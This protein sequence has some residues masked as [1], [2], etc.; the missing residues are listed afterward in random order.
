[1]VIMT[2]MEK[3]CRPCPSGRSASVPVPGAG[4][5]RLAGELLAALLLVALVLGLFWRVTGFEFVFDDDVYVTDV[6]AVRG[7]LSWEG[8]RWAFTTTHAE[9]WHPLTWISLML[10]SELFGPAPFGF[11]LG[12]L[13]L[14]LAS[15]L[16]LHRCARLLVG[17]RGVA[18]LAAALFAVH[19]L[20]VQTVAWV[21]DRKDVLS[22]FFCLLL[23][24]AYRR[25]AAAPGARRYLLAA[26]LFVLGLMA[27][28]SLVAVPAGLL[29]L[30][31]WPLGRLRRGPGGT[32]LPRLLAEKAPLLLLSIAASFIGFWAEARAEGVA[33]LSD[34]TLPARLANAAVSYVDY[35]RLTLWPTGLAAFYPH[36][37]GGIPVA[38]AVAAFLLLCAI[39]GFLLRFARR[40]PG[41][42]VGWLWFSGLLFPVI[43]LIQVGNHAMADRYTYVPHTVLFLGGA[44]EFLR[45]ARARQAARFALAAG[46]AAVAA[47]SVAAWRQTGLWRDQLTLFR[48]VYATTADSWF[49]RENLGSAL[50]QRGAYAEAEGHFRAILGMKGYT[51][52]GHAPLALA[53]AYQGRLA[54][55]ERHGREGVRLNPRDARARDFLAWILFTR[56]GVAEAEALCREAIALDPV[57]GGA[58]VNLGV[59]LAAQGRTAEARDTFA[60]ALA[61]DPGNAAARANLERLTAP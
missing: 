10:D 56:G 3:A 33:A 36:P 25:Y 52:F 26:A 24:L 4:G 16:L 30:D 43:G 58:R 49:T 45:R 35:L 12:A 42:C 5:K 38:K 40:L 2:L 11:H 39:T 27:K 44:A 9:F 8:V 46:L 51:R 37:R 29:L 59:I 60:Q 41:L 61:I 32:T 22:A 55:A 21:S 50:L 28:P 14:H 15:T 54:E 47:L 6:P 18:L 13:L 1:M 57:Y 19:P 48:N 20:H 7:G 31:W 53:L 23:L 34:V 17:H